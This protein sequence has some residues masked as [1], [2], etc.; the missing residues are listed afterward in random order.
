MT[1]ENLESEFVW[2]STFAPADYQPEFT[3]E[4]E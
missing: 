1:P 4:A 3:V 2:E